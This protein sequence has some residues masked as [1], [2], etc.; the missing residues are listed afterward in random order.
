MR[1]EEDVQLALILSRTLRVG[2]VLAVLVG[3][4]GGALY[5]SAAGGDHVAFHEF[6]GASEVFANPRQVLHLAFTMESLP[7]RIRGASLAE[8]GVFCLILTPVLRVVLSFVGFLR[9]R[10]WIYVGITAI[11]LGGLGWSMLLR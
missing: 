7:L 6:R 9:D 1:N 11:V 3:I 2:V 8:V 10:D 4:S 5:L